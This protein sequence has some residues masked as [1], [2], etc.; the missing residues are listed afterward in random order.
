MKYT[1]YDPL[2]IHSYAK[3]LYDQGERIVANAK[4][5]SLFLGLL[6]SLIAFAIGSSEADKVGERILP[7]PALLGGIV[8]TAV[9]YG[10]W[11]PAAQRKAFALKLQ[12]QTALCQLQIEI[13]TRPDSRIT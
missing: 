5:L 1:S 9:L 4:G 6:V 10:I 13:N 11:V 2:I 3:A 7:L 12:A 8:F